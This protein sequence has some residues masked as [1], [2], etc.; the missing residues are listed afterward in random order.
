MKWLLQYWLSPLAAASLALAGNY[1]LIHQP[2]LSKDYTKIGTDILLNQNAPMHLQKYAKNL[3]IE[4]SPVELP[5]AD[6]LK[7]INELFKSIP[8]T[9]QLDRSTTIGQG[10]ARLIIIT[11]W[12]NKVH[13][14]CP[15]CLNFSEAEQEYK[16]LL[17]KIHN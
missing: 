13:A 8:I 3:L 6:R 14:L 9:P 2:S 16:N 15:D 11:N 4:N 17:L 1:Y 5:D 10:A 7:R 12:A